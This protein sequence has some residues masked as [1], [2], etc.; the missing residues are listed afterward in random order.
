MGSKDD[1]L[2]LKDLLA[3]M[4]RGGVA[5]VVGRELLLLPP[6]PDGTR[7]RLDQEIARKVAEELDFEVDGLPSPLELKDAGF[8]YLQQHPDDREQLYRS[9][10]R[11]LDDLGP[12]DVPELHK[13]A[14]I[15]DFQVFVATTFD[16]VLGK[17]LDEVRFFGAD[18]TARR[19]YVP[20]LWKSPAVREEEPLL[21]VVKRKDPVVYRIFGEVSTLPN[22]AVTEADTLEFVHHLQASP[23]RDL[24]DVLRDKQLLFLGCGFSDWLAR[25]FIRA[26]KD[27]PLAT[28]RLAAVV[29]EAVRSE[30]RLVTFL[31]QN[32]TR[33]FRGA[34]AAAF[35][36]KLHEA[37]R[38]EHA[39]RASPSSPALG[40]SASPAA[41]GPV[42]V[43]VSY[44]PEDEPLWRELEA[45]LTTIEKQGLV[46]LSSDAEVGAGLEW[47]TTIEKQIDA[48]SVI[49]FLGSA[50][51]FASSLR[52]DVEVAR[53]QRI[54]E[55]KK[56][57]V[58]LIRVR[59]YDWGAL[60]SIPLEVLPADG[61]PVGNL[62][63]RDDA[64]AKIAKRIRDI[65]NDVQKGPRPPAPLD[66]GG[67]FLSSAP[68]DRDAVRAIK[69]ELD[70][71]HVPAWLDDRPGGG[72]SSADRHR[73]IEQSI[74]HCSLFV[75][76]LSKR[77]L[78]ETKGSFY[79]EWRLALEQA[80]QIAPGVPF[81]T[82][83]AL[84][85]TAKTPPHPRIPPAFLEPEWIRETERDKLA[86]RILELW[87]E[88]K[89]EEQ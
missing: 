31:R 40:T 30:E 12:V 19:A 87:R 36:D 26:M 41:T 83:A 61:V 67:V 77:A 34:G 81:I 84:D 79:E 76:F 39:K 49:L 46:E 18:R 72:A 24:F 45:H 7:L 27:E 14:E 11:I 1:V 17:T 56:A 70:R 20:P 5:V 55:G 52:Q 73:L 66:E 64:W 54:A 74:D 35:V 50:D 68:D 6:G 37:W 9:I 23:P 4:R 33:V 16:D 8:A 10:F 2:F 48:A 43:F 28:S 63:P 15:L 29:D 78:A 62:D 42:R 60:P 80:K 25:F 44:A 85:E 32:K 13:L 53:A 47:R 69:Q 89:R 88:K 59:D 82:P 65:V 86:R 75:P 22:Y 71:L 21:G 3:D 38:A 57:R 51:F 58:V